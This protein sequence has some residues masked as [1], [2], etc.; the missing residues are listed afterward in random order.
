MKL[1]DL[2]TEAAHPAGKEI[3]LD[4]GYDNQNNFSKLFKTK[5]GAYPTDY[6]E[7]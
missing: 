7:D 3:A 2:T 6:R 1:Y 5:V 4:L